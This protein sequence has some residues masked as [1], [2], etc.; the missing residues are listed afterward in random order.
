MRIVKISKLDRNDVVDFLWK[1]YD[2]FYRTREFWVSRLEF[3]WDINPFFFK[4]S[5]M[6]WVLFDNKICGIICNIPTNQERNNFILKFNNLSC[7]YLNEN[8][9]DKSLNLFNHALNN[10]DNTIIDNTPSVKVEKI[11]KLLKFGN[12]NNRQIKFNIVITLNQIFKRNKFKYFIPKFIFSFFNYVFILLNKIINPIKSDFVEDNFKVKNPTLKKT[13]QWL[14][15]SKAFKYLFLEFKIGN[16]YSY[17]VFQEREKKGLKFIQ[18][19]DFFGYHPKKNKLKIFF[20]LIEKTIRLKYDMV[21]L[22]N[23]NN[24]FP[25]KFFLLKNKIF[26]NNQYY[27]NKENIKINFFNY[28]IG[29]KFF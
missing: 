9:R 17:A 2:S 5:E 21:I 26:R 23:E 29:D 8:Y 25:S 22:T 6:G 16:N 7:W 11:L 3:W 15:C 19:I 14:T 13:M 12:L 24:F 20:K 28:L 4:K 27:F 18:L 1:D 10:L